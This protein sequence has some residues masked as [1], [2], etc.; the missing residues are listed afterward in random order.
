MSEWKTNRMRPLSH[1]GIC[2][3]IL[4]MLSCGK[5]SDNTGLLG[6][7]KL[8]SFSG[9]PWYHDNPVPGGPPITP[10][11]QE[12]ITFHF[13]RTYEIR[14]SDTIWNSGTYHIDDL[15]PAAML[16]LSN[17]L[18]KEYRE[19]RLLGLNKDTLTIQSAALLFIPPPICKY[20]RVR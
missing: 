9:Q 19:Y 15:K 8:V 20:V 13:D 6:K 10:V 3:A 1:I 16:Y 7:W 11:P 17:K 5:S 4:L 14:L 2:L 12:T 18:F